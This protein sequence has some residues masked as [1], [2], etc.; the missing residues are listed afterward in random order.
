MPSLSLIAGDLLNVLRFYTRLPLPVFRFEPAAH[1][2]PDF[3]RAAWAIPITGMVVGLFGALAGGVAYAL[4]LS[5]LIA[6][7]LAVTVQVVLTGAFHEDGLADSCDGLFGGATPERRLEIMKDSRIGTFGG[8]G[9]IL[10]LMLRVLAL[11]E[12][13]RQM[14]PSAL[15]LLPALAA[16]SRVLALVPVLLI[17]PAGSSGLSASVPLPHLRGWLG[18]FALALLP[19]GLAILWLD[20]PEG[21][22]LALLF[23]S[24]L[25]P[26][27]A[28]F[29]KARIGGHTGDILGACQQLAEMALLLALSAAGNWRGPL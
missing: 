25:M 28:S 8:A 24:G 15:V 16:L 19:Y 20:L 10:S 21:G 17:A 18:A 5:T 29:A 2:M 22:L 11:G 26:A 9:L 7:T 4:G 27:A 23:A 1:A 6:A 14:G 3:Q 12:L 13:F